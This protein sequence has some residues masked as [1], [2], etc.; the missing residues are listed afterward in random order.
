MKNKFSINLNIHHI[1]YHRQL[2]GVMNLKTESDQNNIESLLRQ[3]TLPSVFTFT[4]LKSAIYSWA[5]IKENQS[6]VI[7]L[8]RYDNSLV[9]LS[10]LFQGSSKEKPFLMDVVKFH[11]FSLLTAE[12]KA[13]SPRLAS[14][15]LIRCFLSKLLVSSFT[16]SVFIGVS[17][18]MFSTCL[19]KRINARISFFHSLFNLVPGPQY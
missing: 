13:F 12:A 17:Y 4:E 10:A 18:V 16:I 14:L 3:V 9:P 5:N 6:H 2:F 1:V 19:I 8:R 7:K 15:A 11:Q